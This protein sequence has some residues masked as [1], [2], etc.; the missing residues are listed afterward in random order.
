MSALARNEESTKGVRR[1]MRAVVWAALGGACADLAL[2]LHGPGRDMPEPGVFA[3]A[4]AL[5]VTAHFAGWAIAA[6]P[7]AVAIRSGHAR[8]PW[9]VWRR[10]PAWL[11]V[12]ILVVTTSA[13]GVK[14]LPIWQRVELEAIDFRPGAVLGTAFVA[15][16]LAY[17]VH[18]DTVSGVLRGAPV[19]ALAFVVVCVAGLGC[20]LPLGSRLDAAILV[21]EDF[22][23]AGYPARVLLRIHAHSPKTGNASRTTEADERLSPYR[24]TGSPGE[25]EAASFGGLDSLSLIER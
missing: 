17:C 16:A 14:L 9:M 11:R 13:L 4:L 22:F 3:S 2:S 5:T 23:V 7:C 18:R 20:L 24:G 12:S 19:T 8:T 10:T 25:L 21:A 6:A 1:L 15:G